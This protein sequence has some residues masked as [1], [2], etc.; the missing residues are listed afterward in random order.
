[1][2]DQR[3]PKHLFYGELSEWNRPQRKFKWGSNIAWSKYYQM[4]TLE[5]LE[6]SAFDRGSWK[7][8]L[9]VGASAFEDQKDNHQQLKRDLRKTKKCWTPFV[10]CD[11]TCLQCGEKYLSKA[12]L[13][14]HRRCHMNLNIINYIKDGLKIIRCCGKECASK[15]GLK[16]H[17]QMHNNNQETAAAHHEY[18]QL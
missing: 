9:K 11:L 18:F 3:P 10:E 13:K 15:G 12:G 16:R 5:S 14:S 7:R 6:N 4:Q 2:K 1:M 8:S 17:M